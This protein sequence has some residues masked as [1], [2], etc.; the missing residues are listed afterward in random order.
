[1]HDVG[2]CTMW[3]SL[4]PGSGAGPRATFAMNRIFNATSFLLSCLL[5]DSALG[6]VDL[7]G[8]GCIYPFRSSAFLELGHFGASARLRAS[9]RPRVFIVSFRLG[10]THHPGTDIQIHTSKTPNLE[11]GFINY[12]KRLLRLGRESRL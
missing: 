1:M 10:V 7:C 3:E 9:A 4:L 2:L 12:A 5:H 8:P 6:P 11:L